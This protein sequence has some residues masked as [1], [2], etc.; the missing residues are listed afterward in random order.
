ME[1]QRGSNDGERKTCLLIVESSGGVSEN[2][3]WNEHV[4][5]CFQL[6]SL[7]GLDSNGHRRVKS[8]YVFIINNTSLAHIPSLGSQRGPY[9]FTLCDLHL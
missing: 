2:Q 1:V 7:S 8:G 5:A 4:M 6:A 9:H 3:S